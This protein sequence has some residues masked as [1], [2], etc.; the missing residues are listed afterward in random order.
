MNFLNRVYVTADDKSV[1]YEIVKSDDDFNQIEVFRV[2]VEQLKKIAESDDIVDFSFEGDFLKS[3]SVPRVMISKEI[4]KTINLGSVTCDSFCNDFTT[5]FGLL[6]V[7]ASHDF[8]FLNAEIVKQDKWVGDGIAEFT[9]VKFCS[10]SMAV[11]YLEESDG[12][13]K[14]RDLIV[15]K[16]NDFALVPFYYAVPESFAHA[17]PGNY[18]KRMEINNCC[19]TVYLVKNLQLIEPIDII[20]PALINKACCKSVRLQNVILVLDTFLGHQTRFVEEIAGRTI[21]TIAFESSVQKLTEKDISQF[22]TLIREGKE[23]HG[24]TREKFGYLYEIC[25]SIY[26]RSSNQTELIVQSDFIRRQ[27]EREN[28]ALE[29]YLFKIRAFECKT[30]YR[31]LRAGMILIGSDEKGFTTV[32]GES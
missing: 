10:D 11:S 1:A 3:H 2:D 16:N 8:L 17:V 30:G 27:L 12:S 22:I 32:K 21:P 29:L 23:F 5:F 9:N 19:Y 28:L 18:V 25:F 20:S 6:R 31:R 13:F 4:E 24:N 15:S 26:N 14:K 7:G